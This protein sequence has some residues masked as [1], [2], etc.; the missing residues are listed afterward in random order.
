MPPIDFCNRNIYEH[1]SKRPGLSPC[2]QHCCKPLLMASLL[3]VT[4]PAKCIQARGLVR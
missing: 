4:T 2:L 3:A 1:T